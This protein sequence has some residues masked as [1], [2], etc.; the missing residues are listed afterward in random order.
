M[1]L[2]LHIRDDLIA[3]HERGLYRRTWLL[4]NLL[5]PTVRMFGMVRCFRVLRFL[6]NLPVRRQP[7]ENPLHR[8][9]ETA[10]VVEIAARRSSFQA[11]CLEASLTIWYL[12]QREGIDSDLCMGTR[13]A[14]GSLQ[15][16]VWVEVQNQALSERTDPRLRYAVFDRPISTLKRSRT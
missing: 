16:H 8:A 2:R 6:A 12:L 7:P 10:R 13:L 15:V 3:S 5:A 1:N 14:A 4:L 9:R 11:A